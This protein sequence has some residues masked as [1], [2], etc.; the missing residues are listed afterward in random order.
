MQQGQ[1]SEFERDLINE[2]RA[3]VAYLLQSGVKLP[4]ELGDKIEK[5]NQ[6]IG[7]QVSVSELIDVYGELSDLI[8]PAIPRGI[9]SKRSDSFSKT[10]QSPP[11][12]WEM[13]GVSVFSLLLLILLGGSGYVTPQN[14]DANPLESEGFVSYMPSLYILISAA[15][16]AA[17]NNLNSMYSYIV[18]GVYDPK[19]VSSY[20]VRLVLGIVAGYI[21]AQLVDLD[22]DGIYD[23]TLLAILGGYSVEVVIWALGR[24]VETLKT[25][26][27]GSQGFTAEKYQ[28]ELNTELSAYKIKNSAKLSGQLLETKAKLKDQGASDE[29]IAELDSIIADV[30]SN[31][32]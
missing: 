19:Y 21:I 12:V 1:D 23:K 17:F 7:G 9:Y 27:Q 25:L 32:G 6:A 18:A 13:L 4:P 3:L 11:I 28:Q 31:K 5:I 26:I 15:L 24:F 2:I 8:K 20:W 29:M 14:I 16:G 30:V 22:I 10:Q